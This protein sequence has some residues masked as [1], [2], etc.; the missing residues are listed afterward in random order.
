MQKF[1]NLQIKGSCSSER[2]FS[3]LKRTKTYLRSSISEL[4][5]VLSYESDTVNA[6]SLDEKKYN[7]SCD[8]KKK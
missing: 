1:K 2:S 8:R 7:A 4:P 6:I 5:T 3:C